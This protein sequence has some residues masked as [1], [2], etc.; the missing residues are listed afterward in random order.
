MMIRLISVLAA[1]LILQAAPAQSQPPAAGL[2]PPG[3]TAQIDINQGVTAP[4]PIA[5]ANF[6][7]AGPHGEEIPAI[8]RNNLDRSGR[9]APIDPARFIDHEVNGALT[10]AFANW[11]AIQAPFLV[12]GQVYAEVDGRLQVDFRLWDVNNESAL[13]GLK[14]VGTAENWRRIGHKISDAIYQ[15]LT[16]QSGYFDTR[17]AFVAE[18]GPKTKRQRLLGLMDQDGY[19]PTVL[20]RSDEMIFSPRFSASSQELTYMSLRDEGSTIWLHN[21]ES[22]R[23]EVLGRFPGMAFA[24]RFNADG[25]KVAVSVERGGN[26]D[27]YIV[28]L[29]NRAQT[30]RRRFRRTAAG[31]CSTPTGPVRP[32]CT[33]WALTDRA[34]GACPRAPAAIRRRYGVRAA[35]SSPSSN[36]PAASSTSASCGRTVLTSGS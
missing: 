26:S 27:I 2:P 5:I 35:T 21:L 36:R 3:A 4:Q 7:G 10:P 24:P 33:S 31:S 20:T 29:S 34:S 25:S 11:K 14:F 8:I 30:P 17:I 22:G 32:S 16:G 1:A 28:T 15:Q 18:S 23:R 6:T 13:L 12:T 19:G 9:F